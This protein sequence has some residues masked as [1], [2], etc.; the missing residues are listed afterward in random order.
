MPAAGRVVEHMALGMGMC[1]QQQ[2][3]RERPEQRE[4][5]LAVAVA[6]GVAAWLLEQRDM[7]RQ[8]QQPAPLQRRQPAFEEGELIFTEP[9]GIG[10][11]YAGGADDV[12]ERHQVEQRRLPR[13][14]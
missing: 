1:A 13:P 9:P 2:H 8:H 7:H 10:G 4:Q 3:M 5:P 11:A 6:E 14:G 12:V